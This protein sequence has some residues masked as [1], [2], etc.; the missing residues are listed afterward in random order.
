MKTPYF[1]SWSKQESAPTIEVESTTNDSYLT[2][3]GHEVYDL[4]SCSYHL[5]FGLRNERIIGAIKDQMDKLP[6]AGPKA[7]FDLKEEA[8]RKLLDYLKLSSGKIFYTTSG[9][10]SVENAL[11]LARLVTGKKFIIAREGSY[12]GATIGALSAGGDWR[13]DKH[14]SLSEYTLRI[15]KINDDQSIHKLKEVIS[16][17]GADKIAAIIL[18]TI[19]G[20]GG[21]YK[22]SRKWW[23]EV[24]DICRKNNILIILDEIVCG[25]GRTQENFAF[26]HYD[27]KPDFVCMAKNISGGYFPFGAVYVNNKVASEFEDKVLSA[28]TT[29]YGHPIGLRTLMTVIDILEDQEMISNKEQLAEILAEYKERI[30]KQSNVVQVRRKGLLMAIEINKEAPTFKELVAQG[31]YVNCISSNFILCPIYTTTPERLKSALDK[32]ELIIK[33][34]K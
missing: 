15:P 27:I 20:G 9:A 16:T 26:H 4:S 19:T 10:E 5:S 8:T 33:E 17:H 29:N 2:P 3:Q 25:F 18:E 6:V 34:L 24:Q 7:V 31:L 12:H 11:K 21:V 32:L 22:A 23:K 1:F 28:G 14:L 30:S 13:S